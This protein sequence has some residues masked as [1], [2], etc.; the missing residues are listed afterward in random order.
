MKKFPEPKLYPRLT[1]LTLCKYFRVPV[2]TET[3]VVVI[4]PEAAAVCGVGRAAGFFAVFP[5]GNKSPDPASLQA[6]SHNRRRPGPSRNI[7]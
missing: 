7:G 5:V 1:H 3:K 6:A 4:P 2:K